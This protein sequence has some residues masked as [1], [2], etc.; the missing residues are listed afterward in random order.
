M[1]LLPNGKTIDSAPRSGRWE[2]DRRPEPI[3][4]P[5]IPSGNPFEMIII[6]HQESYFILY[7]QVTQKGMSGAVF[8]AFHE[9]CTKCLA[10]PETIVVKTQELVDELG[11][12]AQQYGIKIEKV[13]R[14]KVI[15]V[16]IRDMRRAFK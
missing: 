8:R 14:L 11:S 13:S 3:F 10:L 7:A 12:I 15:P 4:G 5:D 9:A 2:I 16:V 1:F 6:V